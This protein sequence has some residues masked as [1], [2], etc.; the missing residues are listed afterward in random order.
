MSATSWSNSR[1]ILGGR[2]S[3]TRAR[4][5]DDDTVLHLDAD[6]TF[7]LGVLVVLPVSAP[8]PHY[9]VRP[10]LA[11]PAH[12]RRL[13]LPGQASRHRSQGFSWHHGPTG[14]FHVTPYGETTR[15]R[16]QTFHVIHYGETTPEGQG[17]VP[18]DIDIGVLVGLL[19]GEGHFGGDG[20]QP[21][22]TLRMH[23]RH[24]ALFH[25]LEREFPGGKL[26]GPYH[27]SGRHYYQ[28]M[29]RGNVPE[30]GAGAA[31]A[32]AHHPRPRR[33]RRPAVRRDADPLRQDP[34]H[35]GNSPARGGGDLSEEAD[36]RRAVHGEEPP[37]IG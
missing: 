35:P 31:A 14:Q 7:S 25:W 36:A 24:E 33:P 11:A 20:R 12:P 13:G 34:R 29:A 9:A 4:V 3:V 6:P 8:D 26:Y 5:H 37:G 32:S 18:T 1:G 27:H 30:G 10:A 15:T 16:A 21:Q 23:V 28:W 17:E 22:I 19:V 2:G